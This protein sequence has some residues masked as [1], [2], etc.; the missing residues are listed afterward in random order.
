MTHPFRVVAPDHHEPSGQA[1]DERRAA[2]R[3]PTPHK[4]LR[5]RTT[6]KA[7]VTDESFTGYG[8]LVDDARDLAMGQPV[9]LEDGDGPPIVGIIVHLTATENGHWMIGVQIDESHL[10]I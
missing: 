1:A 4:E 8:L 10:P 5:L 7:T 3:F 6:R 9:E 2:K